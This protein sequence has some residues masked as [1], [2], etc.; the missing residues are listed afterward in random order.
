MG[1]SIEFQT[2]TYG[3]MEGSEAISQQE[4]N[5][6]LT[7][8]SG[9][10]CSNGDCTNT[11]NPA[12]EAWVKLVSAIPVAGQVSSFKCVAA[13]TAAPS[14][15]EVQ[16]LVSQ[17]RPA[18]GDKYALRVLSEK[19]MVFQNDFSEN[20]ET[21]IEP[22]LRSKL[23][24]LANGWQGDDFDGFAGQMETVFANC[25]QIKSDIGDPS[26][27]MAGLLEQKASEIFALQGGPSYELPYPAPQY[28]VED[29]GGLF[30]NP[31]VHVRPPFTDGDCE[32]AEGCMFGDGDAEQAME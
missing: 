2:D 11:S 27:G 24:E 14:P 15:E 17:I 32:V 16:S 26:S 20:P 28:W 6:D 5:A 23:Q 21:A 10:A 30:S 12:E 25:E 29:K 31:K 22:I 4:F 7:L 3:G 13:G 9:A 18:D 19:W 1:D 8:L